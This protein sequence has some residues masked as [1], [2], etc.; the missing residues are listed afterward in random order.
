[1]FRA[2]GLGRRPDESPCG[3]RRRRVQ[4]REGAPVVRFEIRAAAA[5]QLTLPIGH[6]L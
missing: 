6:D 4:Q 3:L 5:P 2:I 1:M